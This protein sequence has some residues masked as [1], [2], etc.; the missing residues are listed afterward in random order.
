LI[1]ITIT[2]TNDVP[3]IT[4]SVPTTIAFSGGTSTPG[5]DL[6]TNVPTSGSI[7]FDDPDL[8]DTH[9]VSVVLGSVVLGEGTLPPAPLA[10][11]EHALTVWIATDSTGI[12]TV[13]WNLAD[14]P[15]YLA[16]FIPRGQTLDLTYVITVTDSQGATAT[17]DITVTITGTDTPAVV[18]IATT[19]TGSA[20]GGL[21]SDA[22]NWETGTV[23]TA[24][25][26]VII[27]IN[28]LIGLT[29]SYPVIINATAVAGSVAMNDFGTSPRN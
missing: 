12:G 5:G 16:D 29:P 2:G 24:T 28:Q 22:S 14:L 25:D 17:Q 15:V 27:I 26:D 10:I 11:F 3:V 20:P 7:V 6:T 8:T 9:T 18:W 21:W 23:P 19:T 1:T 13:N 4:S